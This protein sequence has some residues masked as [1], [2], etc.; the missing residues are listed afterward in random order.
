MNMNSNTLY[1][2][3]PDTEEII[4]YIDRYSYEYNK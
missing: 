1:L 3:D 4:D 2:V